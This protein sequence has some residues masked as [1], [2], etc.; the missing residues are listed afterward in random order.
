M[1]ALVALTM[2]PLAGCSGST[3]TAQT[4]GKGVQLTVGGKV[5]TSKASGKTVALA[6]GDANSITVYNA[7]DGAALGTASVGTDGKFSGLTFTLPAAKSILV[8]KATVTQ[9]VFRSIVPLDLSAPVTPAAGITANNAINIAISQQ[10]TDIAAAVSAMLGVTGILGDTGATLATAGKTYT[11]AATQVVNNGGQ[12]LAYN[13]DGLQFT[14]SVTSSASLLPAKDATTFTF[15]DLNDIKLDSKI[16]SA[17][18]PGKNPIVNFQV[19]NLATGKG[20]SGLKTFGLHIAKLMPEVNGS[21]SYWVNYIDKGIAVPAGSGSAATAATKPSADPGTSINADTTKS[22]KGYTVIDHGDGTYTAIF[23]SDV[24]S[25]TNADGVHGYDASATTRIGVTVTTVAVPGVTATGPINPTTNVVSPTFNPINRQAIVYDF[26]PATGAALVDANSKPIFARD[27]VTN[28]GCNECH[29]S[30]STIPNPD[31][32]RGGALIGHAQRPNVRLCVICHTNANTAGEGEFV[33]FIHRIHMGEKL[34]D[35]TSANGSFKPIAAG[36]VTYGEH[37]YP[38]DIRNC[39]KCHTGAEANNWKNKANRKNCG[40]CHNATNF[41][42]HQGG[43]ATDQFCAGCHVGATAS[44]EVANSHITLDPTMHNPLTPPGAS[45]FTYAITGVSLNASKQPVIVFQIKKDGTIVT[46]LATPNLVTNAV[47]GAQVIDP[48]FEPIPG[49]SGGP[50]FYVV[51]SVPQDGITA[52]ADFN[53]RSNVALANLLVT[54]GS[55]KQGSITFDAATNSF[56]ATLTGDTV[57]QP[58]PT[59]GTKPAAVAASPIFV[60]ASAKMLTGS[61][62]GNFVQKNIAAYPYTAANVT[63]SPNTSASGGLNRDV[64]AVQKVATG[65]TARRAIVDNAKCGKCHEQLGLSIVFHGGARNDATLCAFC[66]TA[67]QTSSGW[68]ANASSFVHGIHAAAKRSVPYTWHAVSATDTYYNVTYPG[69]LRNCEQCHLTGTNDLSASAY[70]ANKAALFSNLLWP[71]VAAGKYDG[72]SSTAYTLSPY[73][74]KD[75]VTD[76]GKVF[77]YTPATD[78]TVPAAATTLV[79]S[80]IASACFSCHDTNIAKAHMILQGGSLYEA[81]STALQKTE[82]C[83]VCHGTAANTLNGSVPSIKAAHRWW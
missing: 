22:V 51:Y 73:V 46:S 5:D 10:T 60:P 58:L 6:A 41:A 47:S 25:N 57:G 49:F 83:V 2:L 30:L 74:I 7:Q 15:D 29:Y 79:S 26:I 27:T 68:T 24:T 71:T 77:S 17:F 37:T 54:A 1:L 9:G 48:A 53:A 13:T 20:I 31:P 82:T 11:D 34:N 65:F 21:T 23:A 18:I 63:V 8:F 14:G 81:R 75:N 67:N 52:P 55:P 56:T 69:Y 45:N 50:S 42:A 61:L 33:T 36:L 3:S 80:P 72:A 38:Q 12:V 40:S 19:T 44:I 64:L 43:Q 4:T 76:Y 66:H 16:I 39:A 28:E 78:V 59:T 70:T 35:T 62:I 32:T